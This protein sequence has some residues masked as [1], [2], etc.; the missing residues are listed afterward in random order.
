[1]CISINGETA[2][3]LFVEGKGFKN[4]AVIPSWIKTKIVNR[5]NYRFYVKK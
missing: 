3:F 4:P 5:N 1:M 2:W